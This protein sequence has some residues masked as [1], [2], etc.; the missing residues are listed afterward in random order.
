MVNSSM[1]LQKIPYGISNYR[2][3][4]E[5]GYVYVDKMRF[6]RVLEEFP[7]P[8]LFFLRPRRFGK[9]LFVSLLGSYYDI[10]MK[11]DFVPL[12]LGTEIG[13]NPHLQKISTIYYTSIFPES[14]P[15]PMR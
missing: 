15:I 1:T 14:E 2:M 9:S 6:F 7:E 4:R 5:E 12:F 10:S 3:M 8:Y 11:E 13:Q